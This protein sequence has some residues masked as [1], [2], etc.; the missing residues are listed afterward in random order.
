MDAGRRLETPGSKSNDIIT[1]AA[2]AR[3]SCWFVLVPYCSQVS[4]GGI[5][6]VI[7]TSTCSA[8]HHRKETLSLGYSM[9]SQQKQAYSL[10]RE[11]R[12]LIAQGC[13]LQTQL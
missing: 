11:R 12:Y 10:F 2:V 4:W 13:L 6:P 5:G 8:L 7:D 1:A 9:L 3:A